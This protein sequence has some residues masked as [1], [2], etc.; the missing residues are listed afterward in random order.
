VMFRFLN[1][2]ATQ[3]HRVALPGHRFIVLALDGNPVPTP[4]EVGIVELGPGER[5]DAIVVMNQPG[6]W[7]LGDV[8]DE[9]RRAGLGVVV[10]YGGQ[11]GAPRWIAPAAESWDYT[12]FGSEGTRAETSSPSIVPLVFKKKFAGSR[13][14]DNWTVNGKMFPHTDPIRLTLGARYRLRLDNRSEEAHPVHLHRN[15]FEVVTVAGRSTAGVRKDVIVVPP[16]QLVEVDLTADAAGASL[17]HCHNQLHMDYG[18]M[19]V[20]ACG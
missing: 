12:Q 18:F 17:L 19:T 20:I 15:T 2:N 5:V 16:R 4:R 3:T 11:S 1:A 9:V 13:W 10:E 8:S 7:A 6:I 14:V